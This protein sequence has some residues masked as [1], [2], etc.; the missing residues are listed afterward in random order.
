MEMDIT[1]KLT[2]TNLLLIKWIIWYKPTIIHSALRHYINQLHTP[3]LQLNLNLNLAEF[4][5]G[6]LALLLDQLRLA[7]EVECWW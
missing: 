5:S 7:Y 3:S 1:L 4:E 6:N 2:E